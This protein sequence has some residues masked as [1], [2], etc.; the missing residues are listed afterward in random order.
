MEGHLS[1][2]GDGTFTKV[3]DGFERPHQVPRSQA[4]ELRHLLSL[5]DTARAL[6]DAEAASAE[7]TAQIG[8]LRRYLDRRYDAYLAAYGPLNRYSERRTG[9]TNPKTGQQIMARIRPPQGGFRD[10]PFAPLVYA[11]EEFDPVGQRAAKAA[12]FRQRVVAPRAPRLGADTPA[13]AL[14]IC[15]DTRGRADLAE[16]ARLLGTTEARRPPATRHP[17][18]RRPG[19]RPAGPGRRV[20]VRPGPRQAPRRR[21][22][23]RRRPPVRRQRRRAAQGPARRPDPRARSTPGWARPGSARTTSSSS[24]ARPSMTPGCRSS[25][26]AASCGRSAANDHTVL[27]ASTWGTSRYP[28]PALAQAI[29][30]QRRI[31]VRDTIRTPDGERRV[32]NVED[33]LAAQEKAAELG[34]RFA[35]WAW[36]DPDRA[37]D[38]ARTYNERF[39]NLVLR[40]YDDAELSLP[41]LS[42]AFQPRPHQIAAVARM[43]H[44][45]S[46][47]LFH[48]VGAGKTAEMIMGVTEL[49]RLGLVRKP[50]VVVPN[51]M[52]E[53]FAR[54]WLQLYPQARV[55]VAGR[56]DLQRD[57]RR[58]FVARCATGDWDGIVI[59]RSAFEKI[60]LSAGRAAGL[61]G[62]RAGPDAGLAHHRQEARR[63][64]ADRQAAGGRAAA[65]RGTAQGQTRLRQGPRHHLRGHRHRLPVRRRGPRVQEPAHRSPTSPTRRSTGR[66]APPTWT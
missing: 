5:R 43:I 46:V 24:C 45:P 42:V 16:I 59:S 23:R 65:G 25:T 12:I 52:L 38:L 41:G 3:V 64:R 39:N 44:E 18:L 19:L 30:E 9:R 20:P 50:A 13:D 56:D 48:E 37:A 36:E 17:G 55:L 33:T 1:A 11:L 60:P 7:D 54:E 51:H 29:L 35:E 27:A 63:E 34:E 61:H 58:A 26:P 32:L 6:L 21:A 4:A 47:G 57:R 53:Q 49:R 28:A 22:G 62:P 2:A 31:E 8:Q 66:C 15:L 14:A 10:D 40:S